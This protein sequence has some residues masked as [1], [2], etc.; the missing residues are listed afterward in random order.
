MPRP[1]YSPSVRYPRATSVSLSARLSFPPDTAPPGDRQ[2]L[3]LR[4]EADVHG[5]ERSES[6]RR[7]HRLPRATS[8][9]AD[10]RR[11]E[12]RV[13]VG[14]ILDINAQQIVDVPASGEARL[15]PDF[16][17]GAG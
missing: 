6:S 15:P 5:T 8:A 14:A 3:S 9:P 10:P 12:I 4:F 16:F 13:D 1:R 7:Y 17:I 11:C 2:L